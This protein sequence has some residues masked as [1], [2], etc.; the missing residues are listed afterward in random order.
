MPDEIVEQRPKGQDSPQMKRYLER[1]FEKDFARSSQDGTCRIS[2][3]EVVEARD[4]LGLHSKKWSVAALRAVEVYGD[5]LRN[6]T[7]VRRIAIVNTF[8]VEEMVEYAM[9][10]AQAVLEDDEA[11]NEDKIKAVGVIAAAGKVC[12]DLNAQMLAIAESNLEGG[13]KKKYKNAPPSLA[14]ETKAA[15]GTVT[16]VVA[17][18]GE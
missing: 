11:T 12:G 8:T 10:K 13:E 7:N 6:P 18:N 5:F 16:R 15:D 9:D 17:S 1:A 2:P 3:E 14:M 4:K